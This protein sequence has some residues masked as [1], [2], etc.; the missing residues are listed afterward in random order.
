MTEVNQQHNGKVK[1][2]IRLFKAWKYANNIPISSFYLEMQIAR[3]SSTQSTIYWDLDLKYG[4]KHLIRSELASMND[5][6]GI[7]GRIPACVSQKDRDF[8]LQCMEQALVRIESALTHGDE[9][10][11][12]FWYEMTKVFGFDFPL[13]S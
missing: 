13:S 6:K 1:N 11:V 12:S 4:M 8:S 3:Y 9:N 5:P 7:V 10:N 2:L